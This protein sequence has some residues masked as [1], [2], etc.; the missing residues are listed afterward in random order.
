MNLTEWQRYDRESSG[1]FV[2][3]VLAPLGGSSGCYR[4]CHTQS[5][6]CASPRI[7]DV[8]AK[9]VALQEVASHGVSAGAGARADVPELAVAALANEPVRVA[10]GLHLGRVPVDVG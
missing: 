4:L 1:S 6:F 9:R 2:P 5:T 7:G 3:P 8:R 10:Q